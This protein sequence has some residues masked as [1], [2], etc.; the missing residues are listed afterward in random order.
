VLKDWTRMVGFSSIQK[1]TT[2][3][4]MIAYWTPRDAKYEYLCIGSS[5][6]IESMYRLCR[7]V[8]AVFRPHCLWGPNKEEIARI[9][10]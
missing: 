10:A 9:M 1:C 8:V 5:T 4:R 2:A 3:M 6:A 7:A